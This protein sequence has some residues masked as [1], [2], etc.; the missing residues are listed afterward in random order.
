MKRIRTAAT[1][2]LFALLALALLA[3]SDVSPAAAQSGERVQQELRRTDDALDAASTIVREGD[4]LRAREIL[5]HAF[6]IQRGAWD[7]FHGARLLA[8]GRQTLEARSLAARAV[9]LAREDTSGRER[10]QRE[11]DRA[12][13]AIARA[14]DRVEGSSSAE[15]SRL[16]EEA[17]A[18]LSRARSTFGEQHFLAAMRLAIAAQRLAAQA[19]AVGAPGGARG[20]LRDLERTD[21][22]LERVQTLVTES[23]DEAAAK[24]LEQSRNLQES[25]WAASREG[26]PREAHVRTR[27]ARALANR[28]RIQLGG[29]DDPAAAPAVLRETQAVLD[30]AREVVGPAGD[31]RAR[32]LLERAAE[33]Q[34]RAQASL[35]GRDVRRALAQTRV[36]RQLA[37]RALQLV[38]ESG[39]E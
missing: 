5:D 3:A 4:S 28:V 30:R 17:T 13:Q 34:S 1:R 9:T 12:S 6:A 8:A 24:L 29:L 7:D 10:A 37:K 25:A 19:A 35:D 32:S 21:L 11:M 31:E 14:R 2:A 36:A 26:H 39:T 16:L 38:S 22:L 33:H 15:S 20:L 23:G 27:E 18:L